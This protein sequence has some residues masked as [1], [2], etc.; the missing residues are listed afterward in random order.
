VVKAYKEGAAYY[1][2]KEEMARITDY[3]EEIFDAIEQG[4]TPWQRWTDRLGSFFEKKF[5]AAWQDKE[6]EFWEKFPYY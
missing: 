6:K 2:P 3:L 5:G 4:K 1:V